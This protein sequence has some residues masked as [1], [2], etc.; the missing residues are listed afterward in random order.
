MNPL[1]IRDMLVS[2]LV[3]FQEQKSEQALHR[4]QGVIRFLELVSQSR[5]SEFEAVRDLVMNSTAA[6]QGLLKGIE[7]RARDTSARLEEMRTKDKGER[8]KR[9]GG[10]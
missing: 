7:C 8:M 2:V 9:D 6:I 10:K 4:L 5:E 1:M 3:L